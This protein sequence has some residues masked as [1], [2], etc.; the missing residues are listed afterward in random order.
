MTF[1]AGEEIPCAEFEELSKSISDLQTEFQELSRPEGLPAPGEKLKPM[2]DT[3]ILKQQRKENESQ[4]K[5]P[6][7]GLGE[8]ERRAEQ[9]QAEEDVLTAD[10]EAA[11]TTLQEQAWHTDPSYH[12]NLSSFV[13]CFKLSLAMI[14]GLGSLHRPC[15]VY[16]EMMEI[17]GHLGQIPYKPKS[18]VLSRF[19]DC[20]KHLLTV[21]VELTSWG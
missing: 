1:H 10:N 18:C 14:Y 13:Q 7:A 16:S 2:K 19:V 4:S 5:F 3:T 11:D 6:Q 20:L 12:L 8:E 17:R 15:T 21:L 9:K